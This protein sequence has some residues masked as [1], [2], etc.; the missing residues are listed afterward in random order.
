MFSETAQTGTGGEA[1]EP[2]AKQR[3]G[4]ASTP[5]V[6]RPT[7]A[8]RTAPPAT[9]PKPAKRNVPV[10]SRRPQSGRQRGEGVSFCTVRWTVVRL[11]ERIL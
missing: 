5:A 7:P 4:V 9:R 2:T 8:A 11:S 1:E 3:Q 6:E 10:S